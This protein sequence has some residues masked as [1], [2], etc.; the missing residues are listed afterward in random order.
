ML[1]SYLLDL[2]NKILLY[3]KGIANKNILLL[4]YP[5]TEIKTLENYAKFDSILRQFK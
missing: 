3:L 2:M 1:L 5:L 4:N